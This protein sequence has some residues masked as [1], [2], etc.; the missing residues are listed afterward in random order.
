VLPDKV[1]GG[2]SGFTIV[3]F[4]GKFGVELPVGFM[5]A[6]GTAP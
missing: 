4:M 3:V 2:S 1:V 6:P 5:F